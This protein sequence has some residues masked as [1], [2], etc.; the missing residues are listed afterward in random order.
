MAGQVNAALP[1]L[2]PMNSHQ[3]P[4][5]PPPF[6][7]Q[8]ANFVHNPIVPTNC[9][10]PPTPQQPI[11]M[12][13]AQGS[14]FAGPFPNQHAPNSPGNFFPNSNNTPMFPPNTNI[15]S[16]PNMILPMPNI[17]PISTS[18]S[19]PSQTF[20]MVP[21]PEET[22]PAP[23]FDMPAG[24]MTQYVKLE[25]FD[26]NS[27]DPSELKMPALLPPSERLLQALE[28]FYT[29]PS[30]EHPRNAEGWEKLGLYEFFKAK[31][32]ARKEYETKLYGQEQ[33]RDSEILYDSDSTSLPAEKCSE[34]SLNNKKT[35]S[36]ENSKQNS[37]P[38]R[39]FKEFKETK[40]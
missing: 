29:P 34:N 21:H 40:R 13:L 14:S 7:P 17:S 11:H 5:N 9:A 23:Y 35:L 10:P 36:S 30:H 28:A 3:M 8:Q 2:P 6:N 37:T 24:I 16:Q 25:D 18:A 20:P 19:M 22:K 27:I 32:Q 4:G 38:K 39:V 1:P 15:P 12:T 26:Y 31:S 33:S